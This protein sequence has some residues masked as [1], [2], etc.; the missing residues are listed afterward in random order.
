[1]GFEA[2]FTVHAS[3]YTEITFSESAFKSDVF[4]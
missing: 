3:F 4:S 2:R 1:M